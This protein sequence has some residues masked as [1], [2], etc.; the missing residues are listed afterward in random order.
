MKL[1]IFFLFISFGSVSNNLF[2]Q[3]VELIKSME[4]G[5]E[6]YTDF[7]ITCHKVSGEGT[8]KIFPPVAKSDYLKNFQ[9]ESIKGVKYGQQGKIKVNGIEYNATMPD[10]GLTDEEVADVMNYINNSWGNKISGIITT[11]K[12]KKIIK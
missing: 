11:E 5:K 2:Y 6:V 12:V 10:S 1:L 9:T 4:R 8:S 7:C 3:N